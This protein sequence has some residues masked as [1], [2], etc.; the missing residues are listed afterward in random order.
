M[1][2]AGGTE[3]LLLIRDKKIKPPK[4][5]VDL[6][7]LK[8]KLSYARLENGK[9]RIGA[10]TTVYDLSETFL[11]RD[12]RFAGFIDAWNKFGNIVL[13]FEA[14][15]GGNIN[16][17]TQYS[18]YVTLLLA[19]DASVKLESVK[20]SRELKL[21]EYV[22]DKRT[23]ARRPNEILTEVSFNEPP[24]KSSSSFVKF[25]R[26]EI[27]IAGIVT[28]ATY[29]WVEDGVIKD[30][31]LAFDMVSDKRAPSRAIKT[32]E[33]LRG[34]AF[35]EDVITEAAEKILP[36]EMRRVSDW[37][38]TAEYRMDMSKVALKRGLKLAYSRIGGG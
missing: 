29:L 8:S 31:K 30:V 37:W 2:L 34:R 11:H 24:A 23:T 16:A 26:R 3:L 36:Q 35:S 7:P 12:R 15:I 32:E 10:L 19:F 20:G 21:W 22:V 33:F 4:Y 9:V 13:R 27:L 1:P 18:D 17:A 5:L 14:T 6:L 28:E 38:A 25:D